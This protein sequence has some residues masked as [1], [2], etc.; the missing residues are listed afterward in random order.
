MLNIIF[1]NNYPV[2]FKLLID[3]F[4]I[5]VV[6][7]VGNFN[8]D[9]PVI[10]SNSI[11]N[12]IYPIISVFVLYMLK[13]YNSM[14][15]YININDMLRLIIGLFLS[16][17]LVFLCFGFFNEK[18]IINQLLFFFISISSLISYRIIIKILFSKSNQ[19][20]NSAQNI[21]VLAREIAELLLKEHFTIVQ[22]IR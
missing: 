3:F 12:L 2:W 6:S 22:N 17:T 16:Y 18:S 13:V 19:I 14:F 1:K 8:I 10:Y 15:R 5:L 20:S 4:L 11:S 7:Y 21:M 9:L